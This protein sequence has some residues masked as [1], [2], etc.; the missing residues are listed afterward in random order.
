MTARRVPFVAVLGAVALVFVLPGH[1]GKKPTYRLVAAIAGVP[2]KITPDRSYTYTITLRNTGLRAFKTVTVAYYDGDHVTKS[3]L[4]FKRFGHAG[5]GKGPG[6]TWTLTNLRPG[7]TRQ[8]T[9][10]VVYSWST[11]IL[12]H[13]EPNELVARAPGTPVVVDIRKV[14]RY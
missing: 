13:I 14:A 12:G 6:V 2:Q 1:A 5:V 11:A 4:A 7:A 3:S 9:I 10:V 8:I